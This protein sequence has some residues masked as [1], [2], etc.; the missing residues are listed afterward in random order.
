[1][2]SGRGRVIGPE[3]EKTSFADMALM[4]ETDYQINGRKSGQR[5]HVSL[6]HL[7]EA[8]GTSRAL[9]I[10][11]DKVNEY[12]S[13]R[14]KAGAMPAT[15]QNEL[16]ALKRMFTIAMRAGRVAQRPYIPPMKVRNTRTGFFE[17]VD[18]AAVKARLPE[19]LQ[20]LAE[21]FRFT[22]WRKKEVLRLTW[23]QVDFRAG[24]VR[25]EVGSTKNDDGRVFPFHFYPPLGDLLRRQRE[26]TT[27]I[28]KE[29]GRIITH[30]FH[31]DGKPIKS[32]DDAWRK[33]CKEAGVPGRLVHDFR[34]GAVRALERAGVSRSTAMKLTGHKTEAVYRRYAIVSKADLAD[35]VRK[36]AATIAAEDETAAQAHVVVPLFARRGAHA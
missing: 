15:I 33:A 31:R 14:Q 24:E 23:P 36:L 7:R 18:F 16:A 27:A 12:I 34:R 29:K 11:T 20:P 4:I 3:V 26:H 5:L 8:F 28:E 22:G 25:L 19:D 30:V 32:Y 2:K 35:G 9:A 21:F 17:P 10:T 6:L 13:D 1:V